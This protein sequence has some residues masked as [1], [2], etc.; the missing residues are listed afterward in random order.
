M[1]ALLGL[2]YHFNMTIADFF[3]NWAILNYMFE[4]F[5]FFCQVHLCGVLFKYW[6]PCNT[7]THTSM[8]QFLL[9]GCCFNNNNNKITFNLSISFVLALFSQQKHLKDCL[10]ETVLCPLGCE[11]T[12][13]RGKITKHKIECPQRSVVCG[14]CKE[15]IIYSKIHVSW[16]I[17][18]ETCMHVHTRTHIDR[19]LPIQSGIPGER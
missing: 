12:L 3:F 6:L 16:K 1:L 19:I 15:S 5:T 17:I 9:F 14:H 2:S 11:K 7:F 18:C 8:L 13:Q 4:Y 10:M